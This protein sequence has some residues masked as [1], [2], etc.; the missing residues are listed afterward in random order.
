MMVL[1]IFEKFV[2]VAT[3]LILYLQRRVSSDLLWVAG[4]DFLLGFLFVASFLK[5]PPGEFGATTLAS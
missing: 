3:V 5:T 1:A 2:F 4:I